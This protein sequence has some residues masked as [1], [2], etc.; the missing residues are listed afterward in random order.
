MGGGAD[1]IRSKNASANHRDVTKREIGIPARDHLPRKINARTLASSRLRDSLVSPD[2]AGCQ[3]R[4]IAETNRRPA[5]S[6]AALGG[7]R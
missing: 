5:L 4:P 3:Y 2:F 1:G 7:Q 6:E